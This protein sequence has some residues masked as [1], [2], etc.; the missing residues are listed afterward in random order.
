MGEEGAEKEKEWVGRKGREQKGIEGEERGR[1]ER[2]RKERKG[3]GRVPYL[4][5]VKSSKCPLATLTYIHILSHVISVF[6]QASNGPTL[7]L[8]SPPAE[9]NNAGRFLS[10]ESSQLSSLRATVSLYSITGSHLKGVNGPCP[11]MTKSTALSQVFHVDSDRSL[12][13][14]Q[15]HKRA[16]S[17]ATSILYLLHY[18]HLQQTNVIFTARPQTRFH[19]LCS[20]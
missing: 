1:A 11:R 9:Y 14:V 4:T 3:E 17:Q 12:K 16:L 6:C 13:V 20:N 8:L 2:K 19:K 5:H 7:S 10:N 15:G 18:H